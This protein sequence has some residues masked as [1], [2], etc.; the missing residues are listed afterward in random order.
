MYTMKSQE[1]LEA[2]FAA[3]DAYFARLAAEKEELDA[4]PS[5]WPADQ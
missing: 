4:D 1:E 3:E 2:E 5:L